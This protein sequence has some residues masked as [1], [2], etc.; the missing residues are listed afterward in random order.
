MGT[1]APPS[2]QPFTNLAYGGMEEAGKRAMSLGLIIIGVL[3]SAGTLNLSRIVLAQANGWY[4]AL[5][6]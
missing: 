4:Q 3:I 5:P 1:P 6:G 2:A